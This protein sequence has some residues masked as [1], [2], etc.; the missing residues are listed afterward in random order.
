MTT[1]KARRRHDQR[2]A[3]AVEMAVLIPLV[4]VIVLL[5]VQ[6]GMWFYA[7]SI[8]LAAAEVGARTSAGRY[9]NLQAGLN[10]AQ[11]FADQVAGDALTEISVIGHRS[12]TSTSVTVSGVAVR[13][14]PLPFDLELSQ[15]ATMPVERLT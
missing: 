10:S 8:A 1:T 6:A 7:R 4:F 3:G 11:G 12:A 9:S 15:T 14:V 2:G 5:A 13:V